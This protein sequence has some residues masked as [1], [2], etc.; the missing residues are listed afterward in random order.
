[1]PQLIDVYDVSMVTLKYYNN[2][3]SD[4]ESPATDADIMDTF[5]GVCRMP[6]T[7][8]R[9]TCIYMC[10]HTYAVAWCSS[11]SSSY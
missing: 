4:C 6:G 1:M 3:V 10:T 11:V 7:E 5:G 9:H 2:K 8:D